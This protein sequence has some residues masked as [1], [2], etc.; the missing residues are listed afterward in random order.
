MTPAEIDEKTRAILTNDF[1]V[2]AEKIADDAT[3][4]GTMGL[5][6]LDVV[7]FIMM[8]QQD[9]AFKAPLESYRELDTYA[10]LVAFVTKILA[11]KAKTQ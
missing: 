10:Q 1:K 4:R 5:D 6:S 9:F 2:P 8:M 7:D 3:F 11:D